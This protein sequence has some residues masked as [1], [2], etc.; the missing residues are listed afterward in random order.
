MRVTNKV[1]DVEVVSSGHRARDCWL[2][3]LHPTICNKALT[4]WVMNRSY[5]A[6]TSGIGFC[7]VLGVQSNM[8]IEGL[9]EDASM[10]LSFLCM[11][12]ISAAQ[13]L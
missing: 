13:L 4:A 3:R 8:S 5:K 1:E 2:R 6:A 9:P 12:V 10:N 11:L 7:D